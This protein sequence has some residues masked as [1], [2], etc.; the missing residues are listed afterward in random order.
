MTASRTIPH[1]MSVSRNM[2]CA[3]WMRYPMPLVLATNSLTTIK[4]TAKDKRYPHPGEYLRHGRGQDNAPQ[5]RTA[6]QSESRCSVELHRVD[7]ARAL[8]GVE[9]HRPDTEPK[10]IRAIR[11]VDSVPRS[12]MKTGTSAGPGIARR[13]C[14]DGSKSSENWC[15]R[16]ISV[17]SAM[18]KTIG[19]APARQ[20]AGTG[21]AECR[22]TRPRRETAGSADRKATVRR[23]ALR[24]R[25]AAGRRSSR[26]AWRNTCQR[27]SEAGS[28]PKADRRLSAAT[29]TSAPAAWS[30]SACRASSLGRRTKVSPRKHATVDQAKDAVDENAQDPRDC[31]SGEHGIHVAAMQTRQRG[32]NEPM[33]L[34]AE[35][36]SSDADDHDQ[37]R[38][39]RKSG[40]R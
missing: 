21:S 15:D 23:H 40:C 29:S 22:G 8:D 11:I 14:R 4:I 37:G 7:G 20:A 10:A 3:F 27:T 17:P 6:R 35:A 26:P 34:S 32:C 25:S 38:S 39:T 24:S 18:P 16:P 19:K 36:R 9:Q 31:G 33:P 12:K 2:I 1:H 13:N 30:G 5:P 28:K